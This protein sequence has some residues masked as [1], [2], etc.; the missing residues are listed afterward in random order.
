MQKRRELE[1]SCYECRY[2][3]W[4]EEKRINLCQHED[5]AHCVACYTYNRDCPGYA[6]KEEKLSV[7][8]I[9][10]LEVD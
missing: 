8:W 6:P 7:I 3:V 5:A 1:A 10:R 4:I 2:G 9:K